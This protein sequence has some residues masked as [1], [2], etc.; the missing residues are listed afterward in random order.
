[1]ETKDWRFIK[2]ILDKNLSNKTH[3]LIFKSLQQNLK[4]QEQEKKADTLLG[5]IKNSNNESDLVFQI[6]ELDEFIWF[7]KNP[8]PT[9]PRFKEDRIIGSSPESIETDIRGIQDVINIRKQ[10]IERSRDLYIDSFNDAACSQIRCLRDYIKEAEDY[11]IS[12]GF[13]YNPTVME[14]RAAAFNEE[15]KH[16][17]SIRFRSDNG[18]DDGWA[19][20]ETYYL[21]R[22]ENDIY[23]EVGGQ[24]LE[25]FGTEGSFFVKNAWSELVDRLSELY[26]GEWESRYEGGIMLGGWGWDISIQYDNQLPERTFRGHLSKPYNFIEFTH[27]MTNFGQCR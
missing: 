9:T 10:Y 13:T 19:W 18:Y 3:R 2:V 14:Q 24:S 11:I 7:C 6:K 4:K 27:L 21:T 12:H 5:I 17:K 25:C 15:L 22:S 23:I 1:M 20:A 8:L 16:M 26:M